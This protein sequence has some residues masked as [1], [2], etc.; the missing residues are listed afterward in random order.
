MLR[1]GLLGYGAGGRW[2]H[3]PYLEASEECHLV[4]VVTRSHDRIVEVAA[5]MPRVATY[6][7]LRGLADAGAEAVAI[8]TPPATRVELVRQALDLGLHVVADKPFAPSAAEARELADAARRAGRL[9]AVFHNRRYDSDIRTAREVVSGGR[10]G[11]IRRLDLRF[12]LD[13]ASTLE[14]GPHGGLLRDLGTHVVD[15]ALHLLGPA[16]AVSAHLD[17]VETAAGPT[18][19]SFALTLTHV[20]GA[21][22]HLSATKLA[23]FESREL[24]LVGTAGSYRSDYRDVQ[25]L[26]I[27][28][29][30]RPRA[31]RGEWGFE[32]PERWGTLTTSAGVE[33]VPSAQGDYAAFYDEFARA[34]AGVGPL[35]VSASEGVAV[36][37]VLDA[38]RRAA[39][40]GSTVAI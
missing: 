31:E 27:R 7:T 28:E 4:G 6:P 2:F 36:L 25:F 18:D 9:L 26:A 21:H 34:V 10:L 38:A 33:R 3:A 11:A 22:S 39:S 17:A 5:D 23:G 32:R 20:T 35:P 14:G 16:V 30:R 24:R 1:I 29:G 15:Q 12:D 13:E 37:R 8:S 40:S 19:G